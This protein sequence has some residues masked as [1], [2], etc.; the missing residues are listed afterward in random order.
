MPIPFTCPHCGAQT[1]VSDE[2]AGQSGP[3][4][5][6]GQTITVPGLSSQPFAR[7][8]MAGQT[9]A[10]QGMAGAAGQ[11]V[12]IPQRQPSSGTPWVVVVVIVLVVVVFCGGIL[13][14]L[15]LP[16]VQAAREAARRAACINNMKQLGLAM[17]NFHSAE[18]R[19]P[20]Y[21]DPQHPEY[22]PT[23]WR[24][25]VLPYVESSFVYDQYDRTQ[26]WDSPNNIV[27]EQALS[28]RYQCPSNAN[29]SSTDTDYLTLVG[30][31]GVF[32]QKGHTSLKDITDGTSNT[33][34]IVESN[35]SGV[36]WMEPRDLAVK[37]AQIVSVNSL[38]QGIKSHHP[39]V[40]NVTFCDGSV[41]SVSEGID[42]NVLQGL[43]TRNGGEDVSDFHMY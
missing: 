35:N 26:E 27:L 24:V 12:A 36:H 43:I 34:M 11:G 22:K 2:Y 20:G 9:M 4:A 17:H 5:S 10:G 30:P 25:Q 7:Q 33:L 6:C 41:R 16:A 28:Q 32:M 19:F 21:D 14:A 42:P 18:N 38:G 8:A 40:V 15:L 23:S 13:A 1:T 37:D 39:G 3:C 29:V 31:N